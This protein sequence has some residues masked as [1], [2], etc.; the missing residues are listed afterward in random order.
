MVVACPSSVSAEDCVI[1]TPVTVMV[2]P[3][4][5]H[6]SSENGVTVVLDCALDGTSAAT[7]GQTFIGPQ[8]YLEPDLS[9][10]TATDI[11]PSNTEISTTITST[12]LG[13]SEISFIPITL[14][15]SLDTAEA[16][17]TGASGTASTA[18]STGSGIRTG[19]G[20]STACQT[21]T[22]STGSGAATA[23]A[24]GNSGASRTDSRTLAY[25]ALSAGLLGLTAFL[26]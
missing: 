2:G 8:Y 26:L 16:A 9:I 3:S 20:S 1:L 19:S 18:S 25:S 4:T 10:L 6:A 22:S 21:S 7:C 5:F 12:V 13:P 14:V 17:T 24:S 11:T 23:S 15:D